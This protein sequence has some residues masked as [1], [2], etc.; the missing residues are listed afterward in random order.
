MST[1]SRLLRRAIYL[2]F[3]GVHCVDET[4]EKPCDGAVRTSSPWMSRE[5]SNESVIMHRWLT[6]TRSETS[7]SC[8]NGN[9][10]RG[11]LL[12][13]LSRDCGSGCVA[14][15]RRTRDSSSP[16]PSLARASRPARRGR[17]G[18]SGSCCAT[19]CA[20]CCARGSSR[21]CGPCS[22]TCSCRGC[23]SGCGI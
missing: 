4:T 19:G 16:S 22:S 11:C 18:C 20:P 17:P 23:R 13:G 9:A 15:P 2:L 8:A 5:L 10:R 14:F 7:A 21:D 1:F 6:L 12:R 3:E